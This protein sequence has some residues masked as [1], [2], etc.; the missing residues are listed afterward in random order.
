MTEKGFLGTGREQP[1]GSR[2]KMEAGVAR[3]RCYCCDFV[4]SW[5][6]K[7]L[8]SSEGASVPGQR[9]LGGQGPQGIEVREPATSTDQWID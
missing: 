8:G 3:G 4:T 9:R 7:E 5:L 6:F 2:G 1:S